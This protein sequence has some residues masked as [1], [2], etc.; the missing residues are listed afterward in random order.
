MKIEILSKDGCSYCE[1][2]ANFLDNL[3]LKYIKTNVDKKTLQSRVPG[4][5]VYP[6]IVI[7]DIPIGGYFEL[8]EYFEKDPLLAENPNRFTIFPIRHH[9]LWEMYKKAQ[10]SNWTAEEIDFSSDMDDWNSLNENEQHF[11]KH[12]LAFF[13]SSDG[14]VFENISI[15]FSK[16][17]QLPE[18]R[19][20]YAYQEHNEMVHGETY[21]LLIEKYVK[22]HTE[23]DNIFRAI[24]TISCVAKKADWALKW[25]DSKLP[26]SQRL[27]A[28]ACV[29]GI[30]FSGSFCAIFWL[31]KRGLMP[32][33]SFSNELISR[34]EGLHLEF[35]VEL[36][37]MLEN[38]P[39]ETII[40]SIIQEAVHIEKEFIIDALPCKLI[41][42]DS[43]KMSQYIE[44]V[45]DRLLKQ[46]GYRTIWNT[47]NPF[48][49]MENISLDGKTNFFEKR[50]GDYGKLLSEKTISF[51][52]EF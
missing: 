25:F 11:I 36:F 47:Q 15:N 41:G 8:E 35:A 43:D 31:K 22:D 46:V 24:E 39:S 27:F 37:S 9:N 49:F 18:A 50:V 7:N 44:F 52:D 38:K 16:E 28:F 40:H 48:D 3:N 51:D 32:G 10:A 14:I 13:A 20:F 5:S 1:K 42:M 33:L 45:S 21:S 6:Q 2:S 23:K 26:F 4:A 19:S 29:E 17:I 34:D 30:F 12:I